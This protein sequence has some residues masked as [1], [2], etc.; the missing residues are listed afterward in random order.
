MQEPSAAEYAQDHLKF[1]K[2]E[3]PDVLDQLRQ[4]SDLNS[5][6]SSVGEEAEQMYDDLMRLYQHSRHVQSLPHLEQVQAL[7]SH[8]REA[9][10]VVRH[11]LIYQ[12][13][14]EDETQS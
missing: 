14:P 2:E 8:R 10:E 7:Q 4:S 5:Y 6:L 9:D 1:L 12:P 11:D 13:L 3:R